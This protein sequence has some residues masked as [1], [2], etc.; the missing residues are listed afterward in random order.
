MLLCT[1][2]KYN[3]DHSFITPDPLESSE[4]K[5]G[6]FAGAARTAHA[7]AL[8]LALLFNSAYVKQRK[9]LTSGKQAQLTGGN[10]NGENDQNGT[11]Q[12][13]VQRHMHQLTEHEAD[14][15]GG[16]D[17][18][19]GVRLGELRSW[20][21]EQARARSCSRSDVI[22]Q[23]VREHRAKQEGNAVP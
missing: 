13:H 11:V 23:A 16:D 14:R 2:I 3:T 17:R 8:R 21:E 9:R 10:A 7:I 1:C 22:R 4:I 6:M 19:T 12:R 18:V 5:L 15:Q 20:I